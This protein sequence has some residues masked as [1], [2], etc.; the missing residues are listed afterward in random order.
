MF[1][2]TWTLV[3]VLLLACSCAVKEDRSGCPCCLVIGVQGGAPPYFLSL[4]Q[5][6]GTVEDTL[7]TGSAAFERT[8]VRR[9]LR[10]QVYCA[11]S[12]LYVPGKGLV[13]PPGRDCPPVWSAVRSLSAEGERQAEIVTLHK[14]HCRLSLV[15]KV[16]G[17]SVA[18]VPFQLRLRGSVAGYDLDDKPVAGTF[19]YS[20]LPDRKGAF[21]IGLPRQTDAS[22]TLE[23]RDED[24]MLRTFP[25][26]DYIVQGGYDWAAPDLP[27]LPMEIDYARTQVTFR[28]E[29][30]EKTVE[31]NVV[32]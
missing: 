27:D 20:P 3:L 23:I 18:A 8:V 10:L 22:L 15:F 4:T 21:D 25:L 31:R 12:S 28:L 5:G 24:G 16:E 9:P 13:I 26:G 29:C 30:W 19:D 17:K 14:N 32:I 11:D 6:D 1:S 2:K 7:H